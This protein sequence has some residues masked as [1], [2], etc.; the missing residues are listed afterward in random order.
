[1]QKA[2][3]PDSFRSIYSSIELT[4]LRDG[5]LSADV[6]TWTLDGGGVGWV[7]AAS[8]TSQKIRTWDT[9][10]NPLLFGVVWCHLEADLGTHNLTNIMPPT[11]RRMQV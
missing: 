4:F 1:M 2:Q 6:E 5:L 8:G 11:S 3:L 9:P 10:I 7:E